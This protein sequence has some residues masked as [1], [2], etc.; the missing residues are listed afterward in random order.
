MGPPARCVVAMNS[1]DYEPVKLRGP[2]TSLE[3]YLRLL[4]RITYRRRRAQALFVDCASD[5]RTATLFRRQLSKSEH[6]IKHCTRNGHAT[7]LVVQRSP[8]TCTVTCLTIWS[9]TAVNPVYGRQ[10]R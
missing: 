3:T 6:S 7:L 4:I 1:S 10:A 5:V 2:D 8:T 9:S